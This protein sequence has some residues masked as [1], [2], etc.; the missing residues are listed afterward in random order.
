[1][2]TYID[3]LQAMNLKFGSKL[4]PAEM[5]Q[6]TKTAAVSK[7][8]ANTLPNALLILA[9][10]FTMTLMVWA[11]AVSIRRK[12][13]RYGG[14]SDAAHVLAFA[15]LA[16]VGDKIFQ[17]LI[18]MSSEQIGLILA[19]YGG[20]GSGVLFAIFTAALAVLGCYVVFLRWLVRA[21]TLKGDPA[22]LELPGPFLAAE[23][24]MDNIGGLPRKLGGKPTKT[25]GFIRL[26]AE[27]QEPE[28]EG[29]LAGEGTGNCPRWTRLFKTLPRSWQDTCRDLLVQGRTTAFEEQRAKWAGCACLQLAFGRL[30]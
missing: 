3:K 30:T 2:R 22:Q 15:I 16:F 23:E 1:M 18:S 17:P 10:V 6:A 12:L 24:A 20:Y 21:L 27:H 29:A 26:G 8:P 9:C 4:P 19:G 11:S 7:L 28:D 5:Y 13:G 25:K 14:A